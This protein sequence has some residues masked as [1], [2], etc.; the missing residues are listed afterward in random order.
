[1]KEIIIDYNNLTAAKKI[2]V[3]IYTIIIK[4]HPDMPANH[5]IYITM[6]KKLYNLATA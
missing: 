6:P 2:D 5:D 3:E 4:N 1:M